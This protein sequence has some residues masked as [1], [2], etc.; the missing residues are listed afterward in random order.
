M[1]ESLNRSKVIYFG[2]TLVDL[3]ADTVTS[4]TLLNGQ[5]AHGKDGQPIVGSCMFDSNTQDATATQSDIL[6]GVSSWARGVKL[7]GNMPRNGAVAGVISVKDGV[8]TVPYG[9]HDGS[10]EVRIDATEQ[11]KLIP[12]NI[13]EG[14]NILGVEGK[15][16]GTEGAVPQAK[17][18]TPSTVEQVVLPDDGYNYLSQVTVAAIPYT[19][20]EN[21][22]GGITV[23]IG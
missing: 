20:T 8:Y 1:S 14:I 3:T 7:I 2:Q 23:T 16:T 15:M 12:D 18:V 11:A 22:A 21:A 4:E 13:R 5:T 17:R 9:H 6:D 10:G 19:E